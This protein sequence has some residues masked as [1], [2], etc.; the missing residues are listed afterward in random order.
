MKT[1]DR[2]K[3]INFAVKEHNETFKESIIPN[4]YSRK[5]IESLL[6]EYR[7]VSM[8]EASFCCYGLY[9]CCW[10]DVIEEGNFTLTTKQVKECIKNN[11]SNINK[12]LRKHTRVYT[13]ISDNG[14]LSM[15]VV[16]RDL[17]VMC[18]YRL[19]FSNNKE[20]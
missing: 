20:V 14:D 11:L 13:Q 12:Q 17:P 5:Y 9:N 6:N 8:V 18:D 16:A 1:R 15:L 19:Y 10:Q 3:V 4:K 7:Y 2:Y